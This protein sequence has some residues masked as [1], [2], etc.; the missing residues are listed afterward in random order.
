MPYWCTSPPVHPARR[1]LQGDNC[2]IVHD[3]VMRTAAAGDL[4]LVGAAICWVLQSDQRTVLC[5][6]TA[7]HAPLPH[8]QLG[9]AECRAGRGQTQYLELGELV[10]ADF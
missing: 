7:M 1:G 10:H 8:L 4:C 2:C 3:R 5:A 9:A 6:G